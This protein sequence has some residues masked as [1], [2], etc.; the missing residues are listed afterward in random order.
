MREDHYWANWSPIQL[1][2]C[3]VALGKANGLLPIPSG[4]PE[5]QHAS[6]DRPLCLVSLHRQSERPG[7]QC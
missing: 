2:L 4:G 1:I 6:V 7:K 5:P 3:K